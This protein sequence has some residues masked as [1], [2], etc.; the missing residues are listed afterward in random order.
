MKYG[1]KNFDKLFRDLQQFSQKRD[2]F[3]YELLGFILQ[4]KIIAFASLM[5]ML[6]IVPR[7]YASTLTSE[8]L[9]AHPIE[10]LVGE[11][12]HYDI[13][14]LWFKHL[15]EGKIRLQRGE[16]PGTYLALMEAKTLGFAAFVTRQRIE[17]YRTLM[18]IGPDGR[19]WPIEHSSHTFKGEGEKQKEKMTRYQF[20]FS[21]RKVH[22]KKIKYQQVT[23]DE[24]LPLESDG[25]VF[26]I[27]SAFY[28][29]RIGAY[30]GITEA[31]ISLPTF[32]RKGIEQIEIQPIPDPSLVDGRFFSRAGRLCKVLV[33]PSVFKTK[34]RE[35]FIS[36]DKENRLERGII[37][38][39]IGLGDVKGVLRHDSE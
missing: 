24:W 32:Y 3:G 13:S 1:L 8:S 5:I 4:K 36:F 31:S 34:G 29:L 18:E 17:S 33:D 37:K 38:N 15:A 7:L 2:F 16:Q 27:L 35:L 19:L 12:L 21:G 26:D 30:G 9:S 22:Y 25:P 6:A 10:A 14:F 23:E 11:E 28:N 20:D 39:V